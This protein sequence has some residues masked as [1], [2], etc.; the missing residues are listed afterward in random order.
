MRWLKS[1]VA[2]LTSR[3]L[4]TLVGAAVLALL[5]WFFGPSVALDGWVPLAG[6]LP[7]LLTILGISLL[8]GASNLWSLGR[9]RARGKA[10]VAAIAEPAPAVG[11]AEAAV[12]GTRFK[13][14]ME[15]LKVRRFAKGRLYEL[16]WYLMI[17]P[18]G[19][20]K[21]TALLQSGLRFPLDS[22]QE[23]KGV[24]GT[25]NCD[26]FFTDEAVLLDT[27]GRWTTQDSDRATMTP[28]T[29]SRGR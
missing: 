29:G 15:R 10:M 8:W 28:L 4:I 18:P 20:G 23:L 24:G 22:E 21:T 17:G 2:L 14:A 12:V 9:S 5:V 3:W 1:I 27:A 25:R 16:P 7:R 6:E 26:W 19:S 13:E 11:D